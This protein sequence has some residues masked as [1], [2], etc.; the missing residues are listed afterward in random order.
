MNSSQLRNYSSEINLYYNPLSETKYTIQGITR[1]GL[2]YNNLK[3]DPW[4]IIIE[5]NLKYLDYKKKEKK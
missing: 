3:A 2:G 5:S 1:N 4:K